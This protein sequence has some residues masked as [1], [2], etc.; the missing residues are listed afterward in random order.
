MIIVTTV[1]VTT[2]ATDITDTAIAIADSLSITIKYISA[3]ITLII[4]PDT[5]ELI[6][7]GE[8]DGPSNSCPVSLTTATLTVKVYIS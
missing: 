6:V 8:L 1:I 3:L 2:T 5:V 7:M 4:K